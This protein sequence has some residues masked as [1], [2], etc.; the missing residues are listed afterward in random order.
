[1]FKGTVQ[2]IFFLVETQPIGVQY[3]DGCK[4][5]AISRLRTEILA[6]VKSPG[7]C[8]Y[9]FGLWLKIRALYKKSKVTT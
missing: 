1:M 3:N 2:L 8:T 4:T 5:L 9:I 7:L 6:L